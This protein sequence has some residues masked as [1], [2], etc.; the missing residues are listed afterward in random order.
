V[1]DDLVELLLGHQLAG[2]ALVARL[3]TLLA[4]A[5]GSLGLGAL[6]GRVGRRWARGVLRALPQLLLEALDPRLQAGD[7]SLVA[8][9]ELDQEL[10]A[11]LPA[12]VIDSLGLGALHGKRFDVLGLCPL[13]G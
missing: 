13:W 2:L 1:V 11:G 7:L 3:A 8:G 10:D 5:R 9:G 12:C 6:G 4:G